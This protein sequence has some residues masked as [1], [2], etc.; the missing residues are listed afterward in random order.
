MYFSWLRQG[1]L[2]MTQPAWHFLVST[3]QPLPEWA[4]HLYACPMLFSS[5]SMGDEHQPA[6]QQLVD[7]FHDP[8]RP[9]HHALHDAHALRLCMLYAMKHGWKP[10]DEQ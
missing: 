2:R 7:D 8:D 9:R 3:A 10:E 6:L 5:W 1:Q 4:Q